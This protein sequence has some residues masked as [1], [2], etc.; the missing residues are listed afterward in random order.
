MIGIRRLGAT[1]FTLLALL[2]VS[3]G[4]ESFSSLI[5]D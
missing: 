2:K 3:L 1:F 5:G 4:D